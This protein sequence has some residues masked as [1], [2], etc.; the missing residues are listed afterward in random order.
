MRDDRPAWGPRKSSGA[1]QEHQRGEYGRVWRCDRQ[2]LHY[3]SSPQRRACC[4]HIVRSAVPKKSNPLQRRS[5]S[6]TISRCRY[7]W[8]A[9]SPQLFAPWTP[10]ARLK[11]ICCF[12][13]FVRTPEKPKGQ[14]PAVL[15][16]ATQAS[17]ASGCL[18]HPT[19]L[20]LSPTVCASAPVKLVSSVPSALR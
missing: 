8:A 19:A 16:L 18:C 11:T 17:R 1:L 12:P 9:L 14:R 13:Q 2:F 7:R 15:R 10:R 4:A 20:R 6:A 5:K 3:G